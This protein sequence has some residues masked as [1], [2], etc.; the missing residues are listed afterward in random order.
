[1]QPQNSHRDA[2]S[3]RPIWIAGLVGFLVI[4]LL[5]VAAH[6]HGPAPQPPKP[7]PTYGVPIEVVTHRLEP[8]ADGEGMGFDP[9]LRLRSA[10]HV[11]ADLDTFGGFSG[12]LVDGTRMLALSD[13]GRYWRAELQFDDDRTLVGIGP[14]RLGLLRDLDGSSP[15]A[16]SR[17][18]SEEVIR[19][20]GGLAVSFE[21]EHRLHLYRSSGDPMGALE[22]P[23]PVPLPHPPGAEQCDDNLGMEAISRLADGRLL[24]FAEGYRRAQGDLAGWVGDPETGDWTEL[25]LIPTEGF[26]P[27]GSDPLPDGG[28]LL[29]QRS[30]DPFTGV[31]IRLAELAASD[32]VADTRIRDRELM[33]LAP[34]APVDNFEAIA[35]EPRDGGGVFVYLLSDD[36]FNE[37][38]RTLLLQLELRP[39]AEAADVGD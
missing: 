38:Q 11:E 25:A 1:M 12:L 17:R 7:V 20:P 22:D 8:P 34:P 14:G 10:L 28:V 26:L 15:L 21:G 32:L 13:R 39:P 35:V 33:R 2:P 4:V 29:L 5:A 30:Y 27:T 36:N 19:W 31:R 3:R 23:R 18:D 37:K 24:V 6:F 16:E 9:S